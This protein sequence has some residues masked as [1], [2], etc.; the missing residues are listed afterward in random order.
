[1]GRAFFVFAFLLLLVATAESIDITAIGG[2]SETIDQS[3]LLSGPGSQLLATYE[4]GIDHTSIDI[5]NTLSKQDAWR[6]DV[7]R[8]DGGGWHGDFALYAKR[9]SNGSGQGSVS[10][11]LSYIEIGTTDT[12]L[13]SGA[14][15]LN[16]I[17]VQ[18]QLT[19]MSISV[20][21][22]SYSTTII[23]TLVDI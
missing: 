11:G 13:F 18:Y 19:G 17:D 20:L 22:A 9:T 15:N 23:F 7:R 2:W 21:P 8:V 12:E 4:S 16:H 10:G 3:D 14:G 5:T 6:V 1:M